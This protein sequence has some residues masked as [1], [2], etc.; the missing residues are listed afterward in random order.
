MKAKNLIKGIEDVAIAVV[1]EVGEDLLK[2]WNVYLIN[3]KDIMLEM[4]I[5]SIKGYGK[6]GE[7]EK[8]TSTFRK[9]LGD[10]EPQSVVKLEPIQEELFQLNNEYWVSYRSEG[11]M[12]DKK[13]IFAANSINEAN[14]EEIPMLEK[15]GVVLV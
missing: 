14:M 3:R 9:I 8:I 7:E 4:V 10:V 6:I 2:E 11:E 1:P 12:Y 15:K 5:V 13:Y